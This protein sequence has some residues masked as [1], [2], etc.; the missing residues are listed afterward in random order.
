MGR[1]GG[2]YGTLYEMGR[3]EGLDA[4]LIDHLQTAPLTQVWVR[5]IA[6]AEGARAQRPE[7]ALCVVPDHTRTDR[8]ERLRHVIDVFLGN[9]DNELAQGS[10]RRDHP[11]R[12][13]DPE[14]LCEGGRHPSGGCII[15]RVRGVD[16]EVA[17]DGPGQEVSR[18]RGGVY[19]F[20]RTENQ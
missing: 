16:R 12:A 11:E 6:A 8:R 1:G 4:Y 9:K 15:A 3:H 10:S 17:T 7:R 2:F 13:A 14:R 20:D 19:G 18:I 5:F